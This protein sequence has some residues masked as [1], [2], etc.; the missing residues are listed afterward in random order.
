MKFVVTVNKSAGN[1]SVGEMWTE[2]HIFNETTTLLGVLAALGND[3]KGRNH[4]ITLTLARSHENG[5]GGHD[6]DDLPF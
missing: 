2:T 6:E 1:D 5:I 3:M 4:T